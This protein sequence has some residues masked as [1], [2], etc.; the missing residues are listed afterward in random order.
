MGYKNP[1]DKREWRRRNREKHLEYLKQW[2]ARKAIEDPDYFVR[3]AIKQ[4]ERARTKPKAQHQC[5]APRPCEKCG[6]KFD[7]R[8]KQHRYCA[9]SCRPS[10]H[11]PKL[12]DP[13]ECLICEGQFNP[14]V[15]RQQTCSKKCSRKLDRRRRRERLKA[16]P[17]FRAR[18][19]EKKREL[20]RRRYLRNAKYREKQIAKSKE[21]FASDPQYREQLAAGLR[22]R[23]KAKNE[24]ARFAQLTEVAQTLLEMKNGLSDTGPVHCPDRL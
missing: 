12:L 14:Q 3:A 9:P 6:V 20:D 18:E 23:N 8:S 24:Q 16:D 13:R 7:P 22:R 17:E 21:K 11:T 5:Q 4:R 1:E 10:A 15:P 2:K 19:L